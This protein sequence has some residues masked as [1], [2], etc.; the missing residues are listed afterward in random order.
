MF[1]KDARKLAKDAG[2][3]L[4]VKTVSF[5]GLGYGNARFFEIKPDFK[6]IFY[7]EEKR[8]EYINSLTKEEQTLFFLEEIYD[9]TERIKVLK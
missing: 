2:R 5:S 4:T 1:L 3:K 9:K 6:R 7:G 8:L